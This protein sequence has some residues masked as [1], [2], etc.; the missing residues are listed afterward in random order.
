MMRA[1]GLMLDNSTDG[2]T[3]NTT[4]GSKEV[5]DFLT[6]K[7]A[8]WL[9]YCWSPIL[10]PVGL[11]G[12]TL[13]F[14]V[15]IKPNNRKMSTCIYMVAIS[16]NDNILML[17]AL[18]GWLAY[19]VKIHELHL[20]DCRIMSF[21][22]Q[23][24]LQNTTYQIVAMTIDKFIAIKW[25][26]KAATY[27]TPRRAKFSVIVIYI[28]AIIYNLPHLFLSRLI[29]TNC[30]VYVVGRVYAK[31][32][33][34]ITFAINGIVPFVLLIFMNL[35]I[36][37][38]VK[39]SHKRFGNQTTDPTLPR[40]QSAT[41]MKQR[42]RK[43]AENQLTVMLLLVTTLF[44]VLMVPSCARYLYFTYINRNTPEKQA[45]AMLFY[46]ISSRLFFTNSGINFFLY[47]ISGKR[48]RDD[49]RDILYCKRN[50]TPK[51]KNEMSITS[52]GVT[53]LSNQS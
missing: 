46:Y 15:M 52:V 19:I 51:T 48:F 11:V 50:G 13:S 35:T 24:S 8:T 2:F 53:S 12:N 42:L 45:D 9:G 6:F 38:S 28:S 3:T 5:G 34:W 18:R 47:C 33:S 29:G 20:L 43:N 10:I 36:V 26:H 30:V 41:Q 14:L 21:L 27:S 16:I 31:V 23:L 39:Q 25:P 49:L 17:L 1:T 22:I 37:H 40:Q 4:D 44:L 7:I 32:H